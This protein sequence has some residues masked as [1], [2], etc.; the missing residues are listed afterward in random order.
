MTLLIGTHS[1]S[2]I[3]LT[4][5]GQC[6]KTD[7]GK[8]T[9]RHY[10]FQKIFPA[11]GL[12]VAI[13]HHGEN[14]LFWP[15]GKKTPIKDLLPEFL[16]RRGSEIAA[17]SIQDVANMVEQ[18]F[19]DASLW[20]IDPKSGR[21]VVGFWVCGFGCRSS[22]SKIFE[23]CWPNTPSPVDLGRLVLGGYGQFL[24]EK[25]LKEDCEGVWPGDVRKMNLGQMRRYHEDLYSAALA[26]QERKGEEVFG[27]EK[28]RLIIGRRKCV[29]EIALTGTH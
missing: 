17:A 6:L 5:D 2:N 29:W 14:V 24:I 26:A 4:A 19:R 21:D 27:G 25:Y 18:D 15:K 11:P 23:V 12:P 28:H 22:T 1:A 7:G 13:C 9:A 20:T 16:E 10:D 8:V 3:L